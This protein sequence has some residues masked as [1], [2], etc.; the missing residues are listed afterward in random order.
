MSTQATSGFEIDDWDEQTYVET[1]HGGKL[2]RAHV[3]QMF[4]RRWHS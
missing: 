2:T 4:R 1:E 3:K